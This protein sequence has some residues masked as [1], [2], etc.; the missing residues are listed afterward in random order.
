MDYTEERVKLG[1][2][3]IRDL[4]LEGCGSNWLATTGSRKRQHGWLLLDDNS[5]IV[6]FRELAPELW[7]IH[8]SSWRP[9]SYHKAATGNGHSDN[10]A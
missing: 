7:Q 3:E 9:R 10:M 4:D 6:T 2:R 1:Q 8:L 5:V